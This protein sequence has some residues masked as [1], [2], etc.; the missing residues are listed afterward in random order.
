MANQAT[1]TK[2]E[3][4]TK[5]TVEELAKEGAKLSVLNEL[6]ERVAENTARENIKDAHLL[7]KLNETLLDTVD[8]IPHKN[9]KV[10]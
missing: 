1:K 8:V 4:K 6:Q 5:L 9:N 3:G 10:V 2:Y 7:L